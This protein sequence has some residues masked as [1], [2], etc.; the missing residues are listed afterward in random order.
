LIEPVAAKPIGGKTG[1]RPKAFEAAG[2][3]ST[4]RREAE[5]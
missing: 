4:A 2:A 5:V 3:F 1:R